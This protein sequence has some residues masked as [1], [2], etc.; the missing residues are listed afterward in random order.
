MTRRQ[1]I[2]FLTQSAEVWGAEQ[3]LLLLLGEAKRNGFEPI[4]AVAPKSPFR[5]VLLED[6]Y[7]VVTH[8]FARHAA[9]E[10]G[11]SLQSAHP[12]DFVRECLS[13]LGGAI[14]LVRLFRSY[15]V[16]VAFSVWQSIEVGLAAKIARVNS[17]L[18]LHETFHGKI[19][20]RLVRTVARLFNATIA[21]S[22]MLLATYGLSARAHVIPRPARSTIRSTL[23]RPSGMFPTTVGI[24]GQISPHKGVLD[25]VNGIAK[26]GRDNL[27]LLVVGGRP[28]SLRD[29]YE[30][31]VRA[32]VQSLGPGSTVVERQADVGQL[33]SECDFVVNVSVHEA[34]GRTVLEAVSSGAVPLVLQGG[35]PAEIV[36][37]IK[38]GH[39]FE[40]IDGLVNFVC[41][42]PSEGVPPE[43][44]RRIER[45]FSP[46]VVGRSYFDCIR[47][48]AGLSD[49]RLHGEGKSGAN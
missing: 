15:D 44:I 12:A 23:A 9:L 17:V 25:L 20:V 13:I 7:A 30:E 49:G 27:R 3:S 43:T 18:D 26:L 42:Q 33:M 32:K 11:G 36:S 19:G 39:I 24:F 28:S 45:Q 10:R 5:D 34:F 16:V 21:P 31:E 14:R 38:V 41:S 2:L 35:G 8:R 40:N 29:A 47:D 48:A 1:R 46:E 6:G 4:V 22:A 37:Q